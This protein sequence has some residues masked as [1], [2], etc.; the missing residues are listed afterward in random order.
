MRTFSKCLCWECFINA[1]LLVV[2]E[3]L[4]KM[5]L[6]ASMR[7]RC[8]REKWEQSEGVVWGFFW[9]RPAQMRRCRGLGVAE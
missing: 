2:S 7:L 8:T 1:M 5:A 3:M 6:E 4:L 9:Q